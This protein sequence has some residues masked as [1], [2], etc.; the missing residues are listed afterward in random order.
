MLASMW[1]GKSKIKQFTS[2]YATFRQFYFGM[3]MN[4]DFRQFAIKMYSLFSAM[5]CIYICVIYN[6]LLFCINF[7]AKIH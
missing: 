1:T 4:D 7:F 5:K 2:I 3:H 6:L